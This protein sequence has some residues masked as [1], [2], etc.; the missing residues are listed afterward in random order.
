VREKEIDMAEQDQTQQNQQQQTQTG[1][2]QE[3]QTKEQKKPLAQEDFDR[4]YR[5]W[6]ET[7]EKLQQSENTNIALQQENLS[8]QSTMSET[9]P[10][11]QNQQTVPIEQRESMS[12]EEWNTWFQQ[13]PAKAT[14]WRAQKA[15]ESQRKRDLEQTQD[16]DFIATQTKSREKL[17]SKHPDMYQKD[18]QGNVLRTLEGIPLLN[19]NSSKVQIFNEVI[20]ANPELA[21]LKTGPELAMKDME[22][23]M[24]ERNINPQKIYQQG[25]QAGIQKAQAA[26]AS[27]QAGFTASSSGSPSGAGQE[28]TEIKLSDEEERVRAKLSQYS[29]KGISPKDYQDQK[30]HVRRAPHTKVEYS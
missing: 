28:T 17:V 22:R 26:A 7:E 6:K 30:G 15:Y 24:E 23:I 18:A 27:A 5:Q 1:Q 2:S 10:N 9:I 20:R 8:L 12:D 13:D 4:I 21:K 3:Q 14:D 29:P 19:M 16:R 11:Q 25:E